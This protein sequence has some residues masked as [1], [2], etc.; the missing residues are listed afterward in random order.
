FQRPSTLIANSSLALRL[1]RCRSLCSRYTAT[2]ASKEPLLQSGPGLQH[3]LQ[4]AALQK[5]M[6]QSDLSNH[7]GKSVFIETRGCRMNFADTEVV[8]SIL[9]KA[10][11]RIVSSGQEANIY[12]IM[13]CAIRE[14]AENK[15]RKK[16]HWLS[17]LKQHRPH[18]VGVLGC[19][20]ERLKSKLFDESSVVRVIC[21][22]DAYRD[23]PRLLADADSGQRGANTQLS[24]EETYADV[25]PIRAQPESPAAF[26]SIMRGCDNHCAFCVVPQTRGRERSTPADAVADQVG[27]LVDGGV[28][29]V[30]LLGQ[31]VNSYRD[32]SS[33]GVS[34]A[35]RTP[36]FS[37]VYAERIG[38]LQF[39][40]LLDR[41][42][43]GY[44]A[45]RFR[46]T[47]P[48]PKDFPASLLQLIGERPNLAKQLHLPAQSGS[49]AVLQRMR[50]G[51][52][53]EAYLRLVD[54]ARAA[55]PN[56]AITG[57]IICG[58][59][60]ETEADH[61]DTLELLR[62]VR[63]SF[64]YHYAY[65]VRERTRAHRLMKDDVPEEVKMRRS[66]EVDRVFRD[67]ASADNQL[68]VGQHQLVLIEGDSRRSADWWRG[69]NDQ[70]IR[71]LLPKLPQ[72]AQRIHQ[73]D[74]RVGDFVAARVDSAGAQTL[75]AEPLAPVPDGPAGF[76]SALAELDSSRPLPA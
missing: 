54:D 3:F 11:Y 9:T 27:R 44:P 4:D 52:S 68:S 46:F 66:A 36:G 5:K 76:A 15:I 16:L 23:L 49:T 45:C 22:P 32:V 63:Y 12:L 38:G 26:V 17:N 6:Q 14:G 48:H 75:L 41:L 20:A 24:L 69:R 56:L 71:V 19:M 67:I 30:T 25:N 18:T 42:S 51:Y 10:G 2:R 40:D 58:F 29:E 57:D 34:A 73:F 31:N 13:T 72:S 74:I 21:G 1:L 53:R 59:C 60:G 39:P 33:A 35:G 61:E 8:M 50:R 64:V 55:V 47:S 65:S 43:A 62:L 70:G 37:A 28:R 7:F